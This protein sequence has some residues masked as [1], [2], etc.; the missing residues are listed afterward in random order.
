MRFLVA[1]TLALVLV[2]FEAWWIMLLFGAAAHAFDAPA[3]AFSFGQS[4]LIVAMLNA[5][6][7]LLFGGGR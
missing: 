7:T 6:R 2:A 1:F 4:I 5:A 3:F